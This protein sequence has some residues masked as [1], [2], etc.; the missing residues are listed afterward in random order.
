MIRK[1]SEE[2]RQIIRIRDNC[3]NFDP[4]KYMELH[5]SSDPTAHIGLRLVLSMVKDS[6]YVNSLGL[7]NLTLVL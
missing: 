4:V 6:S 3:I 2:D 7:N 1:C 5:K